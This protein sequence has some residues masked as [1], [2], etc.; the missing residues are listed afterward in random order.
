MEIEVDFDFESERLAHAICVATS[1]DNASVPKDQSI[2]E[3]VN[4][5]TLKVRVSGKESESFLYT[6]E[7][8]FDKVTLCEKCIACLQPSRNR[9]ALLIKAGPYL[10]GSCLR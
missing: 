5:R 7:D 6:I 8:V 2:E 1:P 9:C 4:G 10:S 3:K